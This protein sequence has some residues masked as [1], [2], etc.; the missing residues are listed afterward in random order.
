MEEVA[1]DNGRGLRVG[2]GGAE[3]VGVAEEH[4]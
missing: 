1:R 2:G 3:E 4:Y